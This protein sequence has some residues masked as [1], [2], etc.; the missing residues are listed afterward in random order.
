MDAPFFI[1]KEELFSGLRVK[2]IFR[3]NAGKEA[4]A[5]GNNRLF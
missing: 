4:L 2:I 5:Y 3:A 1:C